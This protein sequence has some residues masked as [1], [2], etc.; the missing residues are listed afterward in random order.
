M[1][2]YRSIRDLDWPLM[3]V[4]LGVCAL[5][6][7]Q[8]YS[9]TLNTR[10][11]DAWWKQMVWVGTGLFMAWVVANLDYHFLLGRVSYFYAAAVGLLVLTAFVGG[12]IFGSTRWIKAGPFTLQ[13]SEFVK[14]VLILLVARYLADLKGKAV[15]WQDLGKLVA[16]LGLPMV[17]VMK[18]PDL[19]TSLT[20][21]PIL[22]CGILMAGLRWKYLLVIT[23][24]LVVTLP[25]GYYF[26]KPY[27]KNR[28]VSFINPDR[29]P[30][31]TGFQVI[32][33][34]IA[35]GN[36][37][38]WGRGAKE[39]SQTHL[40]FL[41][42]PQTDFIFS[43]F[44]EEHGFIGVVVALVLYFLLIMQIV[45]N[46]Q[47]A[48]D[49]AGLYICMG[50]AALLLFHVLVNV[51]MVVGRMPVTGI[52]LPLMSSGGSNTWSIFLMLGLVNSVRLRRFVN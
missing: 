24:I 8:I 37:G 49:M 11:A 47:T 16:L 13:T 25:I 44:A 33:S 50:V 52:P 30:K 46:A 2:I 51:G 7:L 45:Q 14:I 28:L 40:G 31:G 23:G 6:V 17:L 48:T 5:G 26:L 12:R 1:Q 34:R 4:S 3:I 29:D 42:V 10:W 32:Q 9:A 19:G 38:M 27:Q 22:V 21:L 15:T 35:V 39:S 20:Y 18:Q 43:S 36:G 41:P